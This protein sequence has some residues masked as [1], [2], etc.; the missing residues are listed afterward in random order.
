MTEHCTDTSFST[1]R[2]RFDQ[3]C[4]FLGDQEAA[5]LTHSE[6]EARLS[7]DLRELVRL[8]YQ[9]HLDLRAAREQRRSVVVDAGGSRR[10]RVEAGHVRPL[11]TVFGQVEVTRLAYRRRGQANLYPADAAL[12]LSRELASHGLRELSAVESSRGSFEEASDA[13]ART[14]GVRL[15]KRQ[16]EQ[17]AARA[18]ADFEAFY[19]DSSRS[20]A[21]A[22]E[23]DLL[24]LSA[25]GKGI[26][27]RPDA[28]RPATA[29]AAGQATA[30]LAT[31]LSRGEKRN[32]KR[33]AEVGAVY[34]LTPTVRTPTDI[35]GRG[36][37]PP[38]PVAPKACNKWLTASVVDTAATVIGSIFDEAQRRDP[39]GQRTWVALVDGAKHQ[40]DRI[41]AE[42][43]ARDVQV[44]IV[45]AFIHVLEYLWSAAWS[46]HAEGDPAAEKWVAAKA[47]AVLNGQASTVAAAIRRKATTLGLQ[48]QTRRGADRCA[49]YLLAKRD[50][51][52][53]PQALAQGWPI[54]TGIIEGACRHL[55]KDRLDLTGARWGLHGAEAILKLRALR[56]NSDFDQYL[57]FHLN[58][59]RNRV[60]KTRYLND[61]IPTAA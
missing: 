61:T 27:M 7:V 41:Q 20:Q 23:G 54:A 55:V 37:D 5:S 39:T 2:D 36:D 56:S 58:Q 51:L 6:L 15:G 48:P 11:Q 35:I 60:H 38:R 43:A 45:C 59:E 34:D 29:K 10:G 49:D 40:I 25:D 12:N 13:I 52:N 44:T 9:D 1:S 33:M 19:T 26:V 47:L 30:K 3:V 24:V 14:T 46:F 18:A 17:L 4:G 53:Y 21:T 16:L 50:Y 31:R 57:R 8:L 42:A 28:L 32:R 22:T